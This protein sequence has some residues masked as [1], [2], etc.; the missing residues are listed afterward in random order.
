LLLAVQV[1]PLARGYLALQI[2]SAPPD[3]PLYEALQ[4]AKAIKGRKATVQVS[5][6]PEEEPALRAFFTQMAQLC[7]RPAA[8]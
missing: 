1:F 2:G 5:I 4:K 8:P 7:G 6:S 3:N